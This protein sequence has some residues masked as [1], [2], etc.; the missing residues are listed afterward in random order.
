M[1]KINLLPH[2]EAKRKQKKNAFY[3]MLMMSFVVGAGAVAATGSVIDHQISAQQQRNNFIQMENAKLDT[4]IREVAS[5]KQEIE[6]LKARQKAVED[7]QSDRNQPVHLMDEL[8]KQVPEGIYLKS[9]KQNDQSVVLNG[10]AHSNERVSELL[11]NLGNNSPW[12]ERPDLVE[13]RATSAGNKGSR[14]VYEFTVNVRIKR[15]T[16][17]KPDGTG[18]PANVPAATTGFS[19]LTVPESR[20]S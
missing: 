13:I 17:V 12:L 20:Q 15:T 9:F 1:V 7:L 3:A 8:V 5:L 4:Q 14:R 10:V 11:R 16:D 6:G 19:D 18:A 2:R